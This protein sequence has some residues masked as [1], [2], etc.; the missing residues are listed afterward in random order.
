MG[1]RHRRGW[2]DH[3]INGC[4]K[5]LSG[6]SRRGSGGKRLSHR[7]A[8]EQRIVLIIV[9]GQRAI[10]GEQHII[11]IGGYAT[12]AVSYLFVVHPFAR[13][14]GR[15]RL[16]P[17]RI[18]ELLC[19]ALTARQRPAHNA[20]AAGFTTLGGR[21]SVI[22]VVVFILFIDPGI[23]ATGTVAG[24][25]KNVEDHAADFFSNTDP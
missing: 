1:I 10:A 6:G 7:V 24:K 21:L 5:G 13:E 23:I 19:Y 2:R 18:C 16:A 22:V 14:Q 4:S 12:G 15:I 11:R 3:W 17:Q 25:G 20:R 8:V 9:G